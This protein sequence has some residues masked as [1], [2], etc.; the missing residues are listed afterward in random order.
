M[1]EILTAALS[2]LEE[3]HKILND[4]TDTLKEGEDGVVD[5]VKAVHALAAMREYQESL[6]EVLK[7]YTKLRDHLNY[8]VVPEAFAAQNIRTITVEG[9]GRVTISPKLNVSIVKEFKADAYDYLRAIDPD[10][11]T[12]TVNAGTL[13]ALAKSLEAEGQELPDDIFSIHRAFVTSIT[14]VK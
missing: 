4:A 7:K 13:S 10:I 5:P 11:I 8:T 6:A 1:K 12:E 9:V 2:R 14:K 3:F